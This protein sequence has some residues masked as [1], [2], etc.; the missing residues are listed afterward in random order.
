MNADEQEMR[1]ILKTSIISMGFSILMGGGGIVCK[2]RSFEPEIDQKRNTARNMPEDAVFRLNSFEDEPF[3]R[4]LNPLSG[5]NIS[6]A[7]TTHG[8]KTIKIESGYVEIDMC[9]HDDWSGYD[10]LLID[11]FVEDELPVDIFI[12]IWD[13]ETKDYWTRVNYWTAVSPGEN[14]VRIPLNQLFVGEKSRPGRNLI[15]NSIK[16][17]LLG[18]KGSHPTAVFIDNVRL[19]KDIETRKH[20]F[21]GLFA[22]D[23]G[24]KNSP[25]M[26]GFRRVTPEADYNAANGYGF[27]EAKIWRAFNVLQPDPLYQDFICVESGGFAVDL[28][29]GA[30]HVWVNWDN[31]SGYW[32]EVQRYRSRRLFAEGTPIIADAMD[33][34]TFK[35]KY[36]KY[37]NIEDGPEIDTFDK[38][39]AAY[40]RERSF[41][42]E[43]ADGQLNLDFSGEN[44]ACS[45]SAIVL[46][47]KTKEKDGEAFLN[48]ITARRKQFFD[49]AFKRVLHRP[50]GT[51]Q[52]T[53]ADRLQGYVVF[54]RDYMKDVYY[55]DLPEKNEVDAVVKGAGFQGEMEPLT[56]SV[57]P[58]KT[59]GNVTISVTDLVGPGVIPKEDVSI[60]YVSYRLLRKTMEGSV[61]TIAPRFIVPRDTVSVDSGGT[62]RFW[63]TVRVPVDAPPGIYRGAIRVTAERAKQRDIPVAFRVYSGLLD[64]VDVPA[65]PWGYSIDIPWFEDDVKTIEWNRRMAL[66]SLRTLKKNG[67]TS[68]SGMPTMRYSGFEDGRPAIDFKTADEQMALARSVG[69]SMPIVSYTRLEGLDLYQRDIAAMRHAGY[70]DYAAFIKSVFGTI[71]THGRQKDWLPVYFNIGDEPVG[72]DLTKSIE[73]AAAYRKAYPSGPPYFTAATSF[74]SKDSDDGHFKLATEVHVANLCGHDEASVRRLRSQGGDWAFYNGEGRWTYGIY[75]FKAVKEFDMKFRLN[76]H[77][78]NAAGDPYYALDCREDDYAWANATPEGELMMSVEFEREMREGLD[79]Y[80]YLLTLW[81]LATAKNDTKGLDIIKQQMGNFKLGDVSTTI[82]WQAFRNNIA[83]NIERL[84]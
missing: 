6:S 56:V 61:Y 51:Y 75:M 55:N 33:F 71:E 69:F 44:W 36:F 24:E 39:Q 3:W 27:K 22:F 60:G 23:F 66:V 64:A 20:L 53:A 7:H 31:P 76:W 25:L 29:N 77:W 62:R 80:R 5:V 21:D 57:Y 84:R 49:G 4:E 58:S 70:N 83:E 41:D 11:V 43:V 28:P 26:P 12:E 73:N 40:Y 37:W 10:T 67:F 59:L 1:N 68:F 35:E 78:N 8:N 74:N 19:E 48:Y 79:D 46:F 13:K 9:K 2:N 42:I 45:I 81:G 63:L 50:T 82:D 14:T 15:L 30:Y 38:Y 32:G 17:L 54:S 34:E 65:G 18:V 47:P 72:D 52:L 16:R